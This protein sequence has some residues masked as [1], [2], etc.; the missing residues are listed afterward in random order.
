MIPS[1][2][3]VS[4]IENFETGGQYNPYASWPGGASGVTI[5]IGYDLG[6]ATYSSLDDD[7]LDLITDQKTYA[8]LKACVGVIGTPAQTLLKSIQV[9]I[10]YDDAKVVFEERNIPKYSALTAQ[11]FPNCS[12]L[13]GDS[14]GALVSLVFNRGASMNDYPTGSNNRL[15]MRQ[16]RDTMA[17]PNFLPVPGL[18]RSMKRLWVG[19]NEGGL[20]IRRDKEADLFQSG[21]ATPSTTDQLNDQEF[22]DLGN[23]A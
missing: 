9:S 7:W 2:K 11:A 14:F 19:K 6:Y 12:L 5:G 18:I 15:E 16:I 23:N 8:Q 21:L 1:P 20:L 10:P 4:L 22:N 3:A 17:T 13:S